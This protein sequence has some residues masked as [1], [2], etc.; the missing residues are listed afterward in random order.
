VSQSTDSLLLDGKPGELSRL[1]AG[2][3]HFCAEHALGEQ[4]EFDLN[5]VLEELFTNAV[6]HGG[7]EGMSAAVR[8]E[9]KSLSEG[10]FIEIADRGKPFDP[11]TTATPDLDTPLEMRQ[12]GGLG[13]H[14]VRQ[15][16]RDLRYERV[17]GWNRLTMLRP[18]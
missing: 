5:L 18:T 6:Q 1:A 14:L 9:L 11:T 15:I 16:V 7:C 8:I 10:V 13:I 3:S 4:A 2:V 12:I 17:G